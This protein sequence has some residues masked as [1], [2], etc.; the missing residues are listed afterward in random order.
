[1]DSRE[2]ESRVGNDVDIGKIKVTNLEAVSLKLFKA[3]SKLL[4]FSL[5]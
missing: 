2:R 1:M 3:V 5:K 4:E